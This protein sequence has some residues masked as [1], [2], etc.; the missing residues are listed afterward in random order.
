MAVEIDKK[1]SA[2]ALWLC[3][4]V[5]ACLIFT[6]LGLRKWR[7][8][9]F[10]MGDGWL[11]V[12]LMFNGVRMAGD[13]YTNKYGTPL[14]MSVLLAGVPADE[15]EALMPELTAQ[16]QSNLI[17]AGK[18]M[19]AARVAIVVV[20]WSL[21]MAVLDMLR[22]FL[23]RLRWDRQ[24]LWFMYPVVALTFIASILSV[25][26][27]CQDLRLN[28]TLFPDAERCSY[29]AAWITTYE[30]SNIITDCM[31][32]CLLLLLFARA[33]ISK[34]GRAWF[35]PYVLSGI[36]IG[37]EIM[38]LVQGLPFTDILFN[39]I[40]WGSIEV[41]IAASVA[42]VPTIYILLQRGSRERQRGFGETTDEEGPAAAGDAK[43]GP[44]SLRPA[45]LWDNGGIWDGSA[46]L[47]L[48]SRDMTR[49]LM[50]RNSL[51][52]S[53][54]S[55]VSSVAAENRESVPRPLRSIRRKIRS[56]RPCSRQSWRMRATDDNR[57]ETRPKW[58]ELKETGT[59]SVT[60][61]ASTPEPGDA[62][63]RSGIFVAT[64]ISQ[65]VHRIWDL[66]QR[67]RI[68]TIPRRARLGP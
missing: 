49:N 24:A 27:E 25:F 64:E 37:V 8:L 33:L 23:R 3:N 4:G 12:A 55:T 14:S 7:Q 1:S 58:I 67:P 28:W 38:R 21:K 44:P 51:Q 10:T 26:L 34:R 52:G 47:E 54:L 46:S 15:V 35:S 42:T 13:Y 57:P 60:G 5:V 19:V 11:V 2:L 18:L 16:E 68:I 65:E 43:H 22:P 6:R 32:F 30:I 66:D 29:D 53:T 17:L 56:P 36:L 41:A 45:D 39:R 63:C 48:G 62:G 59:E 61:D 9:S 31:L 40:L 20:L 50:S